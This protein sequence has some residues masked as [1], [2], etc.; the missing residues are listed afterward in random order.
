MWQACPVRSPLG[1]W[2]W[3]EGRQ[4]RNIDLILATTVLTLQGLFWE[5]GCCKHFFIHPWTWHSFRFYCDCRMDVFLFLFKCRKTFSSSNWVLCFLNLLISCLGQK[6]VTWI[7]IKKQK[8]PLANLLGNSGSKWLEWLGQ[9]NPL[10][11]KDI[12]LLQ[13]AI[14]NILNWVAY[15]QQNLVL[16]VL[17]AGK[18][19]VKM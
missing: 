9:W 10:P 2:G 8:K 12:A 15:K 4:M 1:E 7:I 5:S 18:S 16:K 6:Y 3:G 13:A 19:K 17:E 14:I 11:P